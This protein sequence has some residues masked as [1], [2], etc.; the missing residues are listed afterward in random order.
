MKMNSKTFGLYLKEIGR[1]SLIN[2]E[3]EIELAK[4]IQEGDEIALT[5]LVLANLKLVVY[6]VKRYKTY[7][8]LW[9]ELIDAGNEGL[10]KASRSYDGR[11]KFCTFAGWHIKNAIHQEIVRYHR[12]KKIFPVSLSQPFN[13]DDGDNRTLLD[14]TEDDSQNPET[15]FKKSRL[16]IGVQKVLVTL[17]PQEKQIIELYFGFNGTKR[18]TLR[19]I[20]K[21]FGVTFTRIGQIKDKAMKRLKHPSRSRLLATYLNI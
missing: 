15:L 8:F 1:F 18:L 19:E 9:D 17:S 13:P 2:R 20:A 6:L 3:T 14:V 4:K 7:W 16:K 12:T 21:Q 11:V 10:K 5:K